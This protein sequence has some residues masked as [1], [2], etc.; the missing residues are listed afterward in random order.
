MLVA[1]V[2]MRSPERASSE[3]SHAQLS[4][5]H[6]RTPPPSSACS[7]SYAMACSRRPLWEDGTRRLR[8]LRKAAGMSAFH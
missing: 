4:L 3:P 2:T 8:L 5:R 7:A 1:S 6:S